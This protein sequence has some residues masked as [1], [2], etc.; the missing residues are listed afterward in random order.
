VNNTDISFKY[1]DT[2]ER[3]IAIAKTVNKLQKLGFKIQRINLSELHKAGG[4]AH[5]L[6][7]NLDPEF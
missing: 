5:C 2:C 1:K 6:T 4:G 7:L 3:K